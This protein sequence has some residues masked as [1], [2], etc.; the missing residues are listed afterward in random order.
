MVKSC[1]NYHKC[2]KVRRHFQVWQN[3]ANDF[4]VKFV[5]Q[6]VMEKVHTTWNQYSSFK[7]GNGKVLQH[8]I[9]QNSSFTAII[10]HPNAHKM[11]SVCHIR[12]WDTKPVA[13]AP[14]GEMKWKDL[15]MVWTMQSIW[16]K[17][18]GLVI[19]P[20]VLKILCGCEGGGWSGKYCVATEWGKILFKTPQFWYKL[21]TAAQKIHCQFFIFRIAKQHLAP[22][23]SHKCFTSPTSGYTAKSSV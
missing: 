9:L 7:A 12:F 23:H 20:K 1:R 19:F 22:V 13:Q 11:G 5:Y 14:G 4:V 6:Q 18:N 2:K 3:F 21:N 8:L 15:E 10:K 17:F 16:L